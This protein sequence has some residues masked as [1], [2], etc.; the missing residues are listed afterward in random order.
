MI[1]AIHSGDYMG[2][3][4]SSCVSRG[5]APSQLIHAKLAVAKHIQLKNSILNAEGVHWTHEHRYSTLSLPYDPLLRYRHQRRL[6]TEPQ[7]SN[8]RKKLNA[9]VFPPTQIITK[10]KLKEKNRNNMKSILNK[11]RV[12]LLGKEQQS[13]RRSPPWN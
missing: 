9:R 8:Q 4:K 1:R 13:S 2:V 6:G 11:E 10:N 12:K 3:I 7:A 5:I